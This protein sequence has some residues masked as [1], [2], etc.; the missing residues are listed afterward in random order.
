M[1]ATTRRAAMASLTCAGL[2]ATGLF[3]SAARALPVRSV[4]E[5]PLRLSREI[6]MVFHNGT[7]LTV[8]RSWTVQFRREQEGS[9]VF[10]EIAEVAIECS[11]QLAAL[12]DYEAER[13]TDGMWPVRLSSG[14]L[15]LAV[16]SGDGQL[17]P[18]DMPASAALLER[19]PD[20]LF[21]PSLGPIRSV[22]A[23]ELPG[24]RIGE[25]TVEYEAQGVAGHGWL[26][27]AVR[28]VVT[29]IGHTQESALERW[30]LAEI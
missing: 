17:P 28:R 27:R 25:F 23:L 4:P 15:I 9:N 21:Y 8:F 5:A 11:P 19:L 30:L 29:R 6:T 22:Q 12:A 7:Q 3:A 1:T 18:D 14:G 26:D 10:G 16:G 20:D 13:R 2:A 24:G